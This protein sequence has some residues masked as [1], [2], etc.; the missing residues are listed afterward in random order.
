MGEHGNATGAVLCC[1]ASP[2]LRWNNGLER[3]ESSG[4]LFGVLTEAE[5]PV[6]QLPLCAG[7]R[8]LLYTDGVTE[9]ENKAGQ[10]FG[11]EKLQG[12]LAQN[13]AVDPPTCPGGS[14]PRS[15]RGSARRKLKTT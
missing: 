5:Y 6:C 8:L 1:G 14:C 13:G 4:L 3:I 7:D 2:L 15:R 11:D 9:P 12:V 10:A